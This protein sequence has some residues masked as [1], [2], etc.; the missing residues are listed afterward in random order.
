MTEKE[1]IKELETALRLLDGFILS[2]K[3]HCDTEHWLKVQKL[4]RKRIEYL[5]RKQN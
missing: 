4:W 2:K 1:E 3:Y 5:K